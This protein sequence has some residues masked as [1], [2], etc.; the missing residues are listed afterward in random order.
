M[1][2]T[3]VPMKEVE[4][5]IVGCG[6][7]GIA[8]CEQLIQHDKSFVV[9][10]DHSQLSSI[11]AAGLYNPVTLKRLTEVWRA[12]EQLAIAMPFYKHLEQK[13]DVK[14]DYKLPI[15]R[16]F[17]SIEEQNDWFA[18][19]DK[20][21]LQHYLSE[22]LIKNDNTAVVAPFGFGR[23]LHSGRVDT[24]ALTG[25]Y[26]NFLKSIN[27]YISE[28]FDHDVLK[29]KI[30][31]FTYR[32]IKAK[33]I[34]FAEGFGM[35]K[36]PYF[37]QLPLNEAKGEVITIKAKNLKID[38]ILK[39]SVFIVPEGN[40]LYSVGS[41]YSWDDKTHQTTE[42]AKIELVSKLEK[43]ITCDFEIITQRAGI[44]PTVRDRRPLIGIHPSH[45]KIAILN[46]L[47]TRGVMIAPYV[48]KALYEHLEMGIPLNPEMDIRRFKKTMDAL[49]LSYHNG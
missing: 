8:F 29:S 23:V 3:F 30:D 42:T 49:K 33:K 39:S 15:Y 37:K 24:A 26:K 36:N 45:Y 14:L 12:D 48:A 44:R 21:T 4:Y 46:G 43:L 13:L 17:V 25:N 7:A 19:S 22:N 10:D 34:V 16:R 1:L 2:F 40:D 6:L 20:P 9:F 18:A 5:I 32:N 11:V 31:S 41:T 38:Y 35:M 27:A 47:G 28:S